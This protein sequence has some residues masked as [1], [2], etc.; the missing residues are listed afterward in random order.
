M[1][2]SLVRQAWYSPRPSEQDS[3]QPLAFSE[4]KCLP[5]EVNT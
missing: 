2:M 4:P 1:E 3:T 5:S